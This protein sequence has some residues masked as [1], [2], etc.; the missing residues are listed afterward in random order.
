MTDFDLNKYVGLWY[1]LGHYPSWYQPNDSY[2]TTAEYSLNDDGSIAVHNST[3]V[4]GKLFES[5]GK[6]IV[7]G[8]GLLRVDFSFNEV[9]KLTRSG[10]FASYQAGIPSNIPNYIIDQYWMGDDGSYIYAVVSDEQ[11]KSLYLLSRTPSP[12]REHY[13]MLISY[14][15]AN[16]DRKLWAATP[17]YQ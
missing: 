10:E 4:N 2:N 5:Y 16:Y 9:S 7:M 1:E 15:T 6:A 17:H 8:V 3:I 12:P 11:K 14:V 13:D